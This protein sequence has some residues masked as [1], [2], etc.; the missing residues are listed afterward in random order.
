MIVAT[1]NEVLDHAEPVR[2]DL[3]VQLTLSRP[4]RTAGQSIPDHERRWVG[5]L[6]K[7]GAAKLKSWGYP[8]LVDDASCVISELVTN[9]LLHGAGRVTFRFLV[10]ADVVV[11]EVT[12]GSP[13][14]ARISEAEDLDESG[15]G[16]LLVS[17]LSTVCGVTPDG[18]TT[19]C[20]FRI[21]H[22]PRRQT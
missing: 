6:R 20:L 17:A 2:D 9:A 14:P 10:I 18:T 8:C 1:V 5:Y 11:I 22:V 15:R 13:V 3:S 4:P 16:M 21:P 12:D 7:I 19:W